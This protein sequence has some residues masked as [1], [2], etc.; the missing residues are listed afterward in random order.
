MPKPLSFSCR[1]VT[2]VLIALSC[3]FLFTSRSKVRVSKPANEFNIED[4]FGTVSASF[5]SSS[6][7]HNTNNVTGVKEKHNQSK[8]PNTVP[9]AKAP[10]RSSIF[11]DIFDN[12][13]TDYKHSSATVAVRRNSKNN[14]N[15]FSFF[16]PNDKYVIFCF[17][18]NVKFL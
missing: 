6:N 12:N 13:S 7:N 2:R 16:S 11:G 4:L 3:V 5:H 10:L 8:Y 18:F 14:N 1:N 9:F 15:L 17:F